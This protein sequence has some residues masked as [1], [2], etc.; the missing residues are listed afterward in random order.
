MAP[1]TLVEEAH[2]ARRTLVDLDAFKASMADLP[3][4]VSVITTVDRDGHRAGGTL[5]AV[6]SLS[7]APPMI[8][9]C[10]DRD[11]NTLSALRGTGHPFLLHILADGQQAIAETFA[12]KSD[13][14]FA[15]VDWSEGP[16]GLPELAGSASVLGCHVSARVPAGDHVI[17]TATAAS[18]NSYPDRVP[19]VYCRRSLIPA[20]GTGDRQ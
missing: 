9:A 7:L 8:L 11:S 15:A 2:A 1:E 6:V 13:D 4:G 14:K 17:V 5:S 12:G 3:A 10:F 18:V 16:L 19:L 20:H